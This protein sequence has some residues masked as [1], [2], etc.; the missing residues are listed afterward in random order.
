MG[1][2]SKHSFGVKKKEKLCQEKC[3]DQLDKNAR[4]KLKKRYF[5]IRKDS[6]CLVFTEAYLGQRIQFSRRSKI[7][8]RNEN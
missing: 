1:G 2:G 3:I 6:T 8:K 7:K 5:I 4:G